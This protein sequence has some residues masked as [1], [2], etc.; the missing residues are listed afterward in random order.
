MA[1]SSDRLIKAQLVKT[2]LMEA[3]GKS[4]RMLGF[5]RIIKKR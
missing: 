4:E 3:Y 2:T 1:F 5:V